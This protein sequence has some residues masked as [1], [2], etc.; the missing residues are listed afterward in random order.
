[1][2]DSRYAPPEAAPDPSLTDKRSSGRAWG[3]LKFVFVPVA[4]WMYA[5]AEVFGHWLVW[6]GFLQSVAPHQPWRNGF[7]FMLAFA[8]VDIALA[9]VVFRFVDLVY[10]RWGTVA[11]CLVVSPFVI[12]TCLSAVRQTSVVGVSVYTVHAFSAALPL[13]FLTQRLTRRRATPMAASKS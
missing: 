9:L 3:T 7:A 5:Q 6:N 12:E 4:M 8:A 10:R 2:S 13:V 1:M 11:A